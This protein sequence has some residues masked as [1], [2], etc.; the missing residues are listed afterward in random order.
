[1]S[2]QIAHNS[3]RHL[4]CDMI[5]ISYACQR[6]K[7]QHEEEAPILVDEVATMLTS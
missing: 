5:S 6:E 1:M 3:S 7:K 4:M 2:L